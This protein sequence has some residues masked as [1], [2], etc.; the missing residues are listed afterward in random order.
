MK[1]GCEV[2]AFINAQGVRSSRV[3]IRLIV[4]IVSVFIA[5]ANFAPLN[6]VV[7]GVGYVV[8][9]TKNQI[10]QNL[11]GGIV[12]HIYVTEGDIVRK[13]QPI[14]EMDRTRFKSAYQEL[15]SQQW[16]LTL[17]LER[18]RVE[19]DFSREFEP[20]SELRELAPEQVASEHQLYLARRNKINKSI[21][22]LSKTIELK[23]AELK[24]LRAMTEKSAMPEIDLIRAEQAAED[25]RSRLDA[26]ITEFEQTRSQEYSEALISLQKI[27]EQIS[28]REDQL[29]RTDVRSPI[30]GVVNKVIATTIGGVV[31]PGD[32]LIEILS[33]EDELHIEGQIDPR[34][35]GFVYSG[36]PATIKLSAFDFS[37]YGAL[38]GT[39]VHVGADT[40]L[41]KNER[42]GEPY[43][44]VFIKLDTS[45]LKG[46]TGYVKIKPGMQAQVELNSG[47]KTVLQYILKPL[48]KA[49]EAFSER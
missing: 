36:M 47:S 45:T 21:D 1:L 18:L 16:A 26:V 42:N 17:K 46:P 39:V 15:K 25:L 31:Q 8:P 6:E 44:E 28:S 7:R 38:T 43:Y 32:P 2:N 4:L 5:W 23:E 48:F 29:L 22:N 37:I 14:A 11:E 13:G 34:D 12:K 10:V 35:I 49:T 27:N 41:D 19:A 30:H 24:I 9:S 20:D 3:Q 33:L 40:I